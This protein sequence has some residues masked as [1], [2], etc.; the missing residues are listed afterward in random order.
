MIPNAHFCSP[1]GG[2][3]GLPI[4]KVESTNPFFTLIQHRKINVLSLLKWFMYK[5]LH[6]NVVSGTN[7]K[8]Y[9]LNLGVREG[10]F[11]HQDDQNILS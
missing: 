6:I 8:V 3:M 2:Q 10:F 9:P 11:S 5:R 7:A 1:L 4:N